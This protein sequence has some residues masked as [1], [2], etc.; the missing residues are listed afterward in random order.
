MNFDEYAPLYEVKATEGERNVWRPTKLND[1]EHEVD[2]EALSQEHPI[3]S[4]I[5]AAIQGVQEIDERFQGPHV[6]TDRQGW[7]AKCCGNAAGC[8]WCA[9]EEAYLKG[10]K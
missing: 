4:S 2:V 8:K 9:M 6:L 3:W 7:T 5:R 1:V 10:V